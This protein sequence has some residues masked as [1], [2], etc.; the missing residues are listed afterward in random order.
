MQCNAMQGSP[1]PPPDTAA[2]SPAARAAPGNG[3]RA[4]RERGERR[5][6]ELLW[7]IPLRENLAA[8]APRGL[9]QSMRLQRGRG[10]PVGIPLM[11]QD[12]GVTPADGHYTNTHTQMPQTSKLSSS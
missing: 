7:G 12:T 2:P 6:G 10:P 9:N 11:T 3:F 4:C 8:L 1:M 5:E